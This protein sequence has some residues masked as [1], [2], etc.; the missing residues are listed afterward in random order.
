MGRVRAYFVGAL[1]AALLGVLSLLNGCSSPP[2]VN[3]RDAADANDLGRVLAA[4]NDDERALL[5]QLSS[6]PSGTPKRVGSEDVLAEAPYNAASGH[7]C[8]ALHLT[9]LRTHTT[10]HRLACTNGRDWFFVPDVFG[11]SAAAPE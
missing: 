8:R 10:N 9:P 3:A 2:P 1:A 5:K 11:D 7:T 6:L 4:K